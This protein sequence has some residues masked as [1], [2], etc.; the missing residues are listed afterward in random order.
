MTQDEKIE[1]SVRLSVPAGTRVALQ[2]S[3]QGRVY[4]M[5]G[6]EY[7]VSLDASH[8]RELLAQGCTALGD[9][10]TVLAAEEA[11]SDAWEAGAQARTAARQA[12]EH[13]KAARRVG[14]AVEADQ[15]ED[16]AR[17]AEDAANCARNAV[18]A[19]FE[20]IDSADLAAADVR[21]AGEAA[22]V[23]AAS[24]EGGPALQPA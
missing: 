20:L 4:L 22:R 8:V 5:I 11:V 21:A 17:V 13:G 18:R 2:G 14:A 6:D 19:A 23:A 1:S 24:G 7:E 10:A 9:S 12:R 3:T 15:V 16:A